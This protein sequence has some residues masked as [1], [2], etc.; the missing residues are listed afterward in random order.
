M[1]GHVVDDVFQGAPVPLEVGVNREALVALL[2]LTERVKE[3]QV[4]LGVLEG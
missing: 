3:G 4:L 1:C 2:H